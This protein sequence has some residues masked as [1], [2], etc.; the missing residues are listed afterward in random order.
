MVYRTSAHIP[1]AKA[2]DIDKSDV[3]ELGNILYIG[4]DTAEGDMNILSS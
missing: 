3:K 4:I 2:K 1:L